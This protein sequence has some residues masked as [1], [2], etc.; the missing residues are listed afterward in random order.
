[1]LQDAKLV[2][3]LLKS[4]YSEREVEAYAQAAAVDI[5]AVEVGQSPYV[6]YPEY[7]RYVVDTHACLHIRRGIHESHIR[8]GRETVEVFV[9][10]RIVLF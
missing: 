9:A 4:K 3:P 2:K 1:M 8:V 7:G 5:G 6:V 10:V